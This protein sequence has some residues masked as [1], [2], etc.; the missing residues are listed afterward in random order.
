[1]KKTYYLK[2]KNNL[3]A[4]VDVV[5]VHKAGDITYPEYR[6][7]QIYDN[8]KLPFGYTSME[9]FIESRKPPKN[10]AFVNELMLSLAT[11]GSLAGHID[12]TLGL[13]L[14]DTY[15]I[16]PEDKKGLRYEDYNL[17]ENPFSKAL[18]LVAFTGNTHLVEGLSTSPE[19]TTQGALR[20]C[21]SLSKDKKITMYKSGTEG[22]AN[23]GCEPYSEYYACQVLNRMG[24]PYIDYKLEMFHNVLVS[25]SVCFC[26]NNLSYATIAQLLTKED[27][28]LRYFDAVDRHV[29]LF[30]K[31]EYIE[32]LV[33]DYIILNYDRHL[34]NYGVYYNP[35]TK[36][37]ISP[38]KI[39][40]NGT[41]LIAYGLK[42]D[43]FENVDMYNKFLMEH[44]HANG[45]LFDT[46]LKYFSC[47]DMNRLASRLIGFKITPHERYNLPEWRIQFL[48]DFIQKRVRNVLE[49]SKQVKV[50]VTLSWD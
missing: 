2:Q 21:W 39:Y 19:Y 32:Q 7:E 20:K 17:Y 48:N 28:G 47:K 26:N 23:A 38:A 25:S 41:G 8:S 5:E 4:S 30:G 18:S 34:Y 12:K 49:I 42:E 13:G 45:L 3:V 24:L 29:E 14:N 15:W 9:K 27:Y 10:R 6:N 44:T 22:Y 43:E 37:I 35:D 36:E 1:M 33:F 16:L 40:D 31:K 11:D 50:P 46:L